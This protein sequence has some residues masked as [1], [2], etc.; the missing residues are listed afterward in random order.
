MLERLINKSKVKIIL[1]VMG[2][3][4]YGCGTLSSPFADY[5]RRDQRI[6]KCNKYSLENPDCD[7]FRVYPLMKMEFK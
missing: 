3:F 1:G 2:L 4:S 5:V 6:Y 7:E